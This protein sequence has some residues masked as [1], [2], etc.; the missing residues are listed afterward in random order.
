MSNLKIKKSKILLI[1][2]CL[3]ALVFSYSCSCR[4]DKVTGSGPNDGDGDNTGTF[5]AIVNADGFSDTLRVNSEN[6][7]HGNTAL[8]IMFT[9]KNGANKV[10]FNVHITDIL[11][12]SPDN[13]LDFSDD[14]NNNYSKYI[15]YNTDTGALTFTPDGLNKIGDQLDSSSEPQDRKVKI[16]FK[17]DADENLNLKDSTTNFTKEFHLIKVKKIEEKDI[18]T[19]LHRIDA[20]A[21]N[22]FESGSVPN[23]RFASFTVN[24]GTYATKIYSINNEKTENK[25]TTFS[26]QNISSIKET[27]DYYVQALDEISSAKQG[28]EEGEV[29]KDNFYKITYEITW[30]D[31]FE[32]TITSIPFKYTL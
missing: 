14:K 11:D 8:S 1:I 16:S 22:L 18:E 6:K 30:E 5:K 17:L 23:K 3:L 20:Q 13:P 19:I 21:E 32:S 2:L 12:E 31:N 26:S 7:V 28:K 9:G 10:A 24:K 29:G 25:M 27:L 4:A 15:G